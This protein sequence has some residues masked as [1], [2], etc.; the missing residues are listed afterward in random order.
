M[1]RLHRDTGQATVEFVALVP[2]L[3]LV[4]VAITT[5]LASF[6]AREAAD[7]A[8]VA[9]AVA[10]LQGRDAKAAAKE[11]A[12][13]WSRARVEISKDRVRVRVQPRVPRAIA[14]VIDAERT[15]T[16]AAGGGS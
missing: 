5:L 2:V 12:P 13:D 14:G 8:A 6:A 7:Q 1:K 11:A 15:V 4:A 9:A 10:Q 3:V 16:F